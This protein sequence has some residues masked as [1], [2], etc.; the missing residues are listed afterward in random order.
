LLK[1]ASSLGWFWYLAG[2]YREGL[3]WL[4]RALS[5]SQNVLTKEHVLALRGAGHLAQTLDAPGAATYLEQALALARTLGHREYEADA[6]LMLGIMAEDQGDY[7]RAADF[8][9]AGRRLA[10]LGGDRLAPIAADYHLGV[11]AYG[12]GDTLE[13]IALLEGA[14]AAA[15]ALGDPLVPTY[16]L[17]WLALI[18]CE[19]GEP[20]R[21]ANLLRQLL[22]SAS[23]M[24]LRHHRGMFLE[25]VGV[26]ASR[27]GAAESTARLFGA[28][29]STARFYGVAVTES[30]GMRRDWPEAVAYEHAEKAARRQLGDHAYKVAWMAGQRLRPE[31]ITAEV[32]RVLTAAEASH[33][34]TAADGADAQLTPREQEVLRLLVAGRSN[35]EIAAALFVSPRTAETHVTHI[36]AKLGVASRAEAAAH[37][38]RVG[39]V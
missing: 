39:L 23:T 31:E 2:H 21:A 34:R 3:G 9:T 14:R 5:V 10:Q 12:R 24:G 17:T 11:V 37:A 36:L 20:G 7:A 16:S 35:P 1:L 8:F 18:A 27:I 32:D 33:A 4:E 15:L 38:V 6:C 22:P 25:T 28:A 13:A 19:Q 29:D 26:L 30:H